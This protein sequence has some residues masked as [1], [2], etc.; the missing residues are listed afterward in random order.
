MDYFLQHITPFSSTWRHRVLHSKTHTPELPQSIPL[1]HEKHIFA[2]DSHIASGFSIALGRLGC[3]KIQ[4]TA[5]QLWLFA[6]SLGPPI[7]INKKAEHF[8]GEHKHPPSVPGSCRTYLGI[9]SL[10]TTWFCNKVS[11]LF[12]QYYYQTGEMVFFCRHPTYL[13]SQWPFTITG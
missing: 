2:K 5:A 6:P 7:I 9:N 10:S 12:V 8:N 4:A 11:D 3:G 13:T 1:V